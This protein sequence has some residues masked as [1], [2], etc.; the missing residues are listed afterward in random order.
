MGYA[1]RTSIEGQ[2]LTA[3]RR[4][5]NGTVEGDVS[6]HGAGIYFC[7]AHEC[8]SAGCRQSSQGILPPKIDRVGTDGQGM[9]AGQFR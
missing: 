6:V 1:T 5:V 8:N 4:A 3:F 7:V 9:T 2:V